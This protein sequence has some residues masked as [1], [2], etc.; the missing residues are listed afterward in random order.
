MLSDAKALAPMIL[1]ITHCVNVLRGPPN[2]RTM[3]FISSSALRASRGAARTMKRHQM[4]SGYKPEGSLPGRRRMYRRQRRM[5]LTSTDWT[6]P[7]NGTE[8]RIVYLKVP[9]S[10]MVISGTW[11]VGACVCNTWALVGP[12]MLGR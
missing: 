12:V 6:I 9:C 11:D 5:Y 2:N 1:L 7:R 3:V 8:L 4:D 10:P